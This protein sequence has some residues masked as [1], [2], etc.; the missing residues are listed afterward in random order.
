LFDVLYIHQVAPRM[1]GLGNAG[2]EVFD[3]DHAAANEFG[4]LPTGTAK[5]DLTLVTF[6]YTDP[7]QRDMGACLEFSTEL[8]TPRTVAAIG[9]AFLDILHTMAAKG[10]TTALEALIAGPDPETA[11]IPTDH[12][13]GAGA[14]YRH[15]TV[16]VALDAPPPRGHARDAFA[17]LLTWYSGTPRVRLALGD[18]PRHVILVVDPD[19]TWRALRER[20]VTPAAAESAPTLHYLGRDTDALPGPATELALSWTSS[21]PRL[22][23][24]YATELFDRESAEAMAADLDLLLRAAATADDRPV[25]ETLA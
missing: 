6:E 24:H 1:E 19:T 14:H 10:A 2:T 18:D 22:R 3:L 5:F 23:L 13:R 21:P 9:D 4:G 12:P 17:A 8:F 7:V 16:T 15:D 20:S 11:V 25:H